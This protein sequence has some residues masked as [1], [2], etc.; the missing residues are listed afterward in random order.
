MDTSNITVN[1]Q[2]SILIDIGKKIYIDPFK[3]EDDTHDADYIFI[4][5]DHYDHYSMPDIHRIL[6]EKT[7][8]IIPA[9]ME[10]SLRKST[11]VGSQI[12]VVPG[13]K[14][15]TEDFSFETVPSYNKLKPFHPKRA[16]WCGYI[17]TLDGVKTFIAGDT[18]A[19]KEAEEVECD[20]AL[21]PI[22]GTYTM[23]YKEAAKL[24]NT[25]K[26]KFAIPTHY[27]SI[28]GDISDGE[29]FS[30]LVDTDIR[31]ELKLSGG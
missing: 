10:M 15:E 27:G 12:S 18:D 19:T 11:P 30:K 28:V 8:F 6:N 13:Q 1:T 20:I 14:Y 3:I 29:K 9:S 31:V 21:I 2:N 4:T 5:H 26:P 24:I 25:I 23:N 16:G 17:I 7:V 22:G